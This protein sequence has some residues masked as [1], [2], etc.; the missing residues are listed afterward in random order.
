M[1]TTEAPSIVGVFAHVDTTVKAL[2]EL[3]AK[4]Y[5]DLTVYT[6]VPV[7]EIEDVL[8]RDKPVSPVRLFTLLGALTGTV[9]GFLLT[10][11]TSMQWGL[12]VGGKP[13]ASIPPFVVI[14]FELTILFGDVATLIGL[15]TLGRL[16]RLRP[17][18]AYDVRFSR[19]R[20]GVAVHCAP[21]RSAS[22]RQILQTA[23]AEEVKA[24]A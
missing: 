8:E 22:V 11:W 20:F 1:A 3:R 18:K 6:P 12:I 13:V 2:E 9:S 24:V 23:G 17:T 19:D 16:P 14:A 5:H 21:D 7:H 15:V 10:I 4:G